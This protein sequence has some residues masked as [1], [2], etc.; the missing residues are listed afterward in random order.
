MRFGRFGR[1][2][3]AVVTVVVAALV[4][5]SG[6]TTGGSLTS[7]FLPS[8]VAGFKRRNVA[9]D[10]GPERVMFGAKKP[11]TN[12]K[13]VLSSNERLLCISYS[14]RKEDSSNLI[15]L[16]DTQGHTGTHNR[17]LFIWCSRQKFLSHCVTK[18]DL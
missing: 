2:L 12:Q 16:K 9:A 17:Y 14:S 18:T 4:L 15:E 8:T 10:S 1:L 3:L 7:S 5:E 13:V 11:E 6:V